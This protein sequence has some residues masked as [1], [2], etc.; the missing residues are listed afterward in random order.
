M[1]YQP[2]FTVAAQAARKMAIMIDNSRYA[3]IISE[4]GGFVYRPKPE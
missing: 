1:I 3:A 2:Y 4:T